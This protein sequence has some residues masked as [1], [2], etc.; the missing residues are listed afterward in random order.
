M[1]SHVVERALVPYNLGGLYYIPG[2]IFLNLHVDLNK[3]KTV[4][5]SLQF[6]YRLNHRVLEKMWELLK[7]VAQL[8]CLFHKPEGGPG[9]DEAHKMDRVF[10]PY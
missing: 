2:Y 9:K 10:R 8:N 3:S 4:D 5:V 1:F 7:D 6:E